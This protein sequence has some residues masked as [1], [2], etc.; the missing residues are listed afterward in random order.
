MAKFMSFF[1]SLGKGNSIKGD[2]VKIRIINASGL[3]IMVSTEE[4]E[5]RN[6]D[7]SFIPDGEQYLA[8]LK[9]GTL[10]YVWQKDRMIGE[11]IIPEFTEDIISYRVHHGG[12]LVL[13]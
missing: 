9:P 11:F 12:V 6:S 7:T 2:T 13:L 10:C 4:Y 3:R 8:S 1:T 5:S